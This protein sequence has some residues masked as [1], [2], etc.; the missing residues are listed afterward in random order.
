MEQPNDLFCNDLPTVPKPEIGTV[1]VTGATGYI[2]GRLVPELLARGYRVRVMVRM[3]SPEQQERWPG[4]EIVVADALNTRELKKALDGVQV[5]Y[6]LIHSMLLGKREFEFADLQ[7]V[8]NFRF[9]AEDKKLKRIIYLSGLG[10][11]HPN[12]SNHLKSRF[13]VAEILTRS[14]IPTT[15][16]RA[17]IIIGSGSASYEIIEHIAKMIRDAG[18]Q[19]IAEGIEDQTTLELVIEMGATHVQG[20]YFDKPVRLPHK[21]AHA[22]NQ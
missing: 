6:Y 21:L 5:A 22:G 8:T 4:A 13:T 14:T 20:F 11:D 16:L 7:A 3:Y 15:I 19:L 17:A 18:Y 10:V 9:I 12:L 2:G 1:L